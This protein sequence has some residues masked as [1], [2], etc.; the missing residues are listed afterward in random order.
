MFKLLN[1]FIFIILLTCNQVAYSKDHKLL[2][3]G[4]DGKQHSLNDFIGKGKW[5]V[6]NVW[7]TACPYCRRELFD[8]AKFHDRHFEKDA[9]VIGLTL[10]LYSFGIP[11]KEYLSN[12]SSTYLIDYPIMLVSGDIASKVIGKT[13][14]TVPM[15]YIYSPKG[16]MVYQITGELTE[17]MLEEIVES[18][19]IPY[20]QKNAKE[21]IPLYELKSN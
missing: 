20:L 12:F 7:A 4:L 3:E 1:L 11:D 2:L 10:D 21:I 19:K 17:Q 9:I 13:V 5:V 15:T 16:E 18:K 6:V 8:L 14:Y